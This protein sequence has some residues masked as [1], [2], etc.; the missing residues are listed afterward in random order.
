MHPIKVRA[1]D[2]EQMHIL[3]PIE[4]LI[5]NSG[6]DYG[7]SPNMPKMLFTGLKDRNNKDMYLHDICQFDNGDTFVIRSEEYIR[8]YGEWIGEVE[9]E[10]QLRD[11][12]RA[13][14]AEII[15]NIYTHPHLLSE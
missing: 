10:D 9:C 2:G 5:L 7:Y 6:Y 8:F 12:Y 13:S 3:P 14:N 15:G 11:W 1:W 4:E